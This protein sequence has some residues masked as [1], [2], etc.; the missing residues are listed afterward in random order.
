MLERNAIE[1]VKSH[2]L[3]GVHVTET[4][5]WVAML[6]K[7]SRRIHFLK[8]LRRVGVSTADLVTYYNSVIRC[9]LVSFYIYLRLSS[10]HTFFHLLKISC[11]PT[12]CGIRNN[13]QHITIA[14]IT[15]CTS[16]Q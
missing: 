15:S 13:L 11:R 9:K 5:K 8:Q 16:L 4:L 10:T 14:Y 2:K 6:S 7:A 3:L 1:N 12:T